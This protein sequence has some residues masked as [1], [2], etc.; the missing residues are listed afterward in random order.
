M[1]K[2]K[3]LLIMS[4]LLMSFFCSSQTLDYAQLEVLYNCEI[5]ENRLRLDK[6]SKDEMMFLIG[7]KYTSYFNFVNYITDSL[8]KSNPAEYLPQV[9]DSDGR[10]QR[11]NETAEQFAARGGNI[12][13]PPRTKLQ[14][15]PFCNEHYLLSRKSG[16]MLCLDKVI[17]IQGY[18]YYSY[19]EMAEKPVWKISIDTCTIAGYRS[20]KATTHYGGRDWTVWFTHEI[21]VS[22]GPWKL[23]GL[24]GLILKAETADGEF[25]LTAASVSRSTNRPIVKD[26]ENIYR[27]ISKKEFIK[28]KKEALKSIVPADYNYIEI[29]K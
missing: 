9:T 22:E 24:P 6:K 2:K 21:P 12:V 10:T 18:I 28:L 25:L 19:T 4:L 11:P 27:D 8:R 14:S 7:N 13:R 16:D 26:Q 17:H 29:I 3:L 1:K 20:Q 5:I 23:R 15:N